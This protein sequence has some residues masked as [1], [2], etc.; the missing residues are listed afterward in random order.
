MNDKITQTMVTTVTITM[1]EKERRYIR[2]LCYNTLE[3]ERRHSTL[4]PSTRAEFLR[5]FYNLLTPP[6]EGPRP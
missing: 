4:S 5:R 6:V 1:S 2:D 3:H